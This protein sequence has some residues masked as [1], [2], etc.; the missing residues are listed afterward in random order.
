[1]RLVLPFISVFIISVGIVIYLWLMSSEYAYQQV[2]EKRADVL[3]LEQVK[4][5]EDYKSNAMTDSLIAMVGNPELSDE[6]KRG[7][8]KALFEQCEGKRMEEICLKALFQTNFI[9]QTDSLNME[10]YFWRYQ[11]QLHLGDTANAM[12]DYEILTTA[13]YNI[14]Q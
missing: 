6:L 12:I 4:A 8:A 9:L 3:M 7:V 14:S 5:L 10:I 11:I 13:G 1:V 2:L